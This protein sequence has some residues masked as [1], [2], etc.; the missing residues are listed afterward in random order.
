MIKIKADV[1]KPVQNLKDFS[2]YNDE[3]L[4]LLMCPVI[5]IITCEDPKLIENVHITYACSPPFACTESIIC[6][7]AINGT[8]IIETHV[9]LSN[10]MD[11]SDINMKIL[12]TVTDSIGKIV[13]FYR[14]I[15]LPMSLYCTPAFT[16][17]PQENLISLYIYSSQPCLV[18]SEIFTGE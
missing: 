2:N 1:G 14:Y 16:N 13:V 18:F 15:M 10:D 3:A 11:I 7:D 8:E 6:L 17:G 4:Y 12:F 5:I 9:F